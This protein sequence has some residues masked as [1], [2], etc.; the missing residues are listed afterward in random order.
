MALEARRIEAARVELDDRVD[1]EARDEQRARAS[2]ATGTAIAASSG[3]SGCEQR[4]TSM[5]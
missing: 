1:A 2:A 4:L 5:R 3:T